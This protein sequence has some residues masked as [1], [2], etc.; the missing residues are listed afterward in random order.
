[1]VQIGGERIGSMAVDITAVLER[2]S[3]AAMRANSAINNF[4]SREP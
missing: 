4:E 3:V 2:V 1:M